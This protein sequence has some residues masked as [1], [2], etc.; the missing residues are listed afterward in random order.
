MEGN[1]IPA[2]VSFVT[3]GVRDLAAMRAFYGTLGW[4]ESA[5]LSSDWFAAFRT[6]GAI[7]C[8]CPIGPLSRDAMVAPPS[9]EATFRGV[10]LTISVEKREQVD[11]AVEGVRAAGGRV[12]KEPADTS[13]GGRSAYFADPEG[14]VWEAAWSPHLSFDGRGGVAP[15]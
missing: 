9:P 2:R 15:P 6:G 8:L 10:T 13:W 7:L 4:E 12:T 3:L 11:S 5:A 1:S 14:N